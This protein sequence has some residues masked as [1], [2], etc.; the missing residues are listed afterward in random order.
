MI[1]IHN[2]TKSFGHIQALK[3]I[4]ITLNSGKFLTIF[5]PNGAGKTTLIKIIS[6]LIK[7]TSGEVKIDGYSLDEESVLIRMKLGVI[8][9]NTYL[10]DNLTALENIIFYCNMYGISDAKN[11]A[12]RLLEDFGL[13]SRKNDLVR[14]FSRGMQQR[15]SI[16]RALIHNPSVILMDEPFTGLDQH[17]SKLL[18]GILDRLHDGYRTIIMTTHNLS[19]GYELS[20]LISIQVSGKIV[21][22]QSK[23]ELSP[24]SLMEIY[25]ENVGDSFK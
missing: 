3:G 17:A 7:P 2:L 9:H 5:G 8:S 13:S 22:S 6:S 21:Y 24:S 14:T 15:V 1:E 16:I 4:N 12:L 19:Q 23:T 25:Y 18:T 10:Y 11:I 20:D